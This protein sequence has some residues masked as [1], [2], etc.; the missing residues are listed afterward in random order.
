MNQALPA[1]PNAQEKPNKNG[2][3]ALI[4]CRTVTTKRYAG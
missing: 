1:K 3:A 2:S 4:S